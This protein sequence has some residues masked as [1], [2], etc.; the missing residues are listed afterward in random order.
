LLSMIYGG[1]IRLITSHVFRP[2]AIYTNAPLVRC[3]YFRVERE[4]LCPRYSRTALS[5]AGFSGD[6]SFLERVESWHV[7]AGIPKKF[8][9]ER[10]KRSR[11]S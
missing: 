8:V 3:A 9:S 7:Q 4:S 10:S 2:L 5:P 6:S 11:E 1:E